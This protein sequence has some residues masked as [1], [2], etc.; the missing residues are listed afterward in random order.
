MTFLMRMRDSSVIAKGCT[1]ND[2]DKANS[3]NGLSEF[4]RFTL[5][6]AIA[7]GLVASLSGSWP[8][9]LLACG[10]ICVIAVSRAIPINRIY[11][12]ATWS[13]IFASSR[14]SSLQQSL[15]LFQHR[16]DHIPSDCF[17]WNLDSSLPTTIELSCRLSDVDVDEP[18]SWWTL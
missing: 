11:C 15:W 5:L 12:S 17:Q 2:E 1:M 7:F 3:N 9:C 14:D 16:V 8:W 10:V 4:L 18:T 13:A 6:G